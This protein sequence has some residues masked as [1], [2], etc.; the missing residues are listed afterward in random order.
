MIT[1]KERKNEC[2]EWIE[3]IIIAVI[4]A[5]I[6]KFFFFEI[7]QVDGNSMYP[8]LHHKDRLIVNKISYIFHEPEVGDIVTFAYPSDTSVDFIKRIVA[9]EGDT[10]EIKNNY[11]YI[12]GEKKEEP[13][14]YEKKMMDFPP[15]VVPSNS[16][17]VLGDNRNNSRDSRY[18]DVGFLKKENI[19][20]KAIFRIWP[21]DSIGSLNKDR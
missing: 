17:F 14:I 12:N 19:K 18:I 1:R 7:I 4:I 15:V 5:S 9:K 10:V 21:L 3:A 13:Y 11:L 20:G 16:F 2:L 8:T 6:I